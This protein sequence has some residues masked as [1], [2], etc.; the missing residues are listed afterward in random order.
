MA[1]ELLLVCDDDPHIRRTVGLLLRDAGY[2]VLSAS[3]AGEA[4]DL[5]AVQRPQLSIVD[6][7]LPD[8][9]GIELCRR[10]R[11]WS[12]MPILVLSAIHDERTKIEALRAGADD[13]VTKPFGPGELVARVQAGLRRA[14]RDSGE[15]RVQIDRLTVDLATRA[16]YIDGQELRLTPIEFS[17]LRTL[18]LNRGMLMTHSQLLSEVWGPQY[19]DA[20]TVLRTHIANLR[21]K[22]RVADPEDRLI[23]TDPGVGYR[24]LA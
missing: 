18:V 13:Y 19:A 10:L 4:L 16:V 23:R 1:G 5:A 21:R 22:L 6:L 20:T 17:L 9:D 15:P 2:E 12:E 24:F 3:S 8:H 7:M 14:T 11:E